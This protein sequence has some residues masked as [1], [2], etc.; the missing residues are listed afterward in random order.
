M[1]FF[2]TSNF[3][4][5]SRQISTIPG[6]DPS[7]DIKGNLDDISAAGSFHE[8][9]VNLHEKF[10]PIASFWFGMV[11]QAV[12]PQIFLW[13]RGARTKVDASEK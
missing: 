3:F 9:L 11:N 4:Q 2:K 1:S 13:D 10:G 7:D 12:A 5:K 6:L 8:F